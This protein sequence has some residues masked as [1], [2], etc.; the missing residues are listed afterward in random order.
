MKSG[1]TLLAV[2]PLAVLSMHGATLT[3]SNLNDNGVGSLRE[4]IAAAQAADTISFAVR[5][6]IVL[7][8]G[9]L[10]VRNNLRIAGPGATNLAVSVRGQGRVLEIL[11]HATVSVFGLTICD[12]H[13]PDGAAGTSNSPAGGEGSDGGGI[14]NL[15]FLTIAQCIVSNCAAGRGGD[16]SHTTSFN[17]STTLSSSPDATNWVGGVGGRGGGIYNAG[18]LSLTDS[19]LIS[20]SSGAGG[21]G[22]GAKYG[23]AG[24]S[25][26]GG[27]AIYNAGRMTLT[28]CAFEHNAAGNG[29]NGYSL[30]YG[31]FDGGEAGGAGGN[32]GAI[33]DTGKGTTSISDCQFSFNA[34]GGGGM[35]ST[36]SYYSQ[37]ALGGLGGAGGGGGAVWADGPVQMN[38]CTFLSNQTGTGAAGGRG[39]QAGGAGGVGGPGGAIC[40]VGDLNLTLCSC[41]SNHA[42]CGG[43]G[44]FTYTGLPGSGASGGSGG[45]VYVQSALRLSD[46]SFSGNLAGSGGQGGSVSILPPFANASGGGVGGY[47]GALYCQY[48]LAATNC[49]FNGNQAGDAGGPGYAGGNAGYSMQGSSSGSGGGQGGGI[50]GVGPMMLQACT[51]SGNLG[52]NGS[53]ADASRPNAVE[54][55]AYPNFIWY[56]RYGGP[57][58]AGGTGG[59]YG[60]NS[61]RMSVCTLSGNLG[62]AGGPGGVSGGG[63]MYEDT[64]AG[65]S[66]GPGGPGAASCSFSNELVLIACTIACNSGG[67][68]GAGGFGGGIGYS[69]RTNVANGGAGGVG[70]IFNRSPEP[71]AAAINTLVGSNL[72]GLGGAGGVIGLGHSGNTGS[73]DL[74]GSFTSLGHN[75]ISRTDGSS[76]FINGVNGDLAGSEITPI[77]PL[78]G[79]LTD[80]GGPTPTMALLHGSPA[81]DAGDDALVRPPHPLTTDQRG[82]PRKSGSHVDIGAFEFQFGDAGAHPAPHVPILSAAFP[83]NGNLQSDTASKD[84][85]SGALVATPNFQLTFNDNTP[86][87]T[88]TVLATTNLSLPF[89]SWSVLGQP[90][91]SSPGLFQFTDAQTTTCPQRF[92]RVSSP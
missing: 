10:V 87:A 6:T 88:F 91:R 33:C 85:D 21:D 65:G 1:P 90:T 89:S 31:V 77:E 67:L 34:S 26:G 92:Y 82:F 75:L 2:L 72:G 47:G 29:G 42:G 64:P 48:D 57:G 38:G 9:E 19:K 11:P 35:G 12:G 45:A 81:L 71:M 63:F 8:N 46:C 79:P 20:N 44:G 36:I 54:T 37:P 5:G 30:I 51:V 73:P 83:A 28:D 53:A 32:G 58:G 74:Q 86:G 62:G 52:G 7:T 16:G 22:G 84:S 41:A 24:S 59:I 15:G 13:A 68:G 70:G 4:A 14:Y 80:N 55:N 3:V 56:V 66:G 40:A 76:G 61:L 43:D 50:F 39:R 78:L 23:A 60:Q 18:K 69:G 25:G 49:R 17:S 27:G